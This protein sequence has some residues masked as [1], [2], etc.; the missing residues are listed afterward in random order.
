MRATA[1]ALTLAFSIA[2]DGLYAAPV[3]WTANAAD[4]DGVF[5]NPVHWSVPME[6]LGV[7][8]LVSMKDNS[9][10]LRVRVPEGLDLKTCWRMQLNVGAGRVA[11]F[12]ASNATLTKTNLP[13]SAATQYAKCQPGFLVSL[14]GKP[15]FNPYGLDSSSTNG[16]YRIENA[17]VVVSNKVDGANVA[18]VDF[19]SGSYDFYAPNGHPLG[20]GGRLSIGPVPEALEKISYNFRPGVSAVLPWLTYPKPE[21]GSIEINIEDADVYFPCFYPQDAGASAVPVHTLVSVRGPSAV[22]RIDTFEDQ[23][24]ETAPH[25]CRVQLSEGATLTGLDTFKAR[26]G[27]GSEFV[28]V[29]SNMVKTNG[30]IAIRA[31]FRLTNSTIRASGYLHLYRGSLRLMDSSISVNGFEIARNLDNAQ[32]TVEITGENHVVTNYVLLC[33][34]KDKTGQRAVLALTNCVVSTSGVGGGTACSARDPTQDGVAEVF[35]NGATLSTRNSGS[36]LVACLNGVYLGPDGLTLD[37]GHEQTIF[38]RFSD[39]PGEEGLLA[40]AGG[41]KKELANSETSVSRIVARGGTTEIRVGCV[42]ATR[43]YATETGAVLDFKGNDIGQGLVFSGDGTFRNLY[44]SS[45]LIETTTGEGCETTGWPKF[46][47]A[48][49]AGDVAVKIVSAPG[50]RARAG[51][52]IV[53]EFTDG[54]PDLSL[55]KADGKREDVK[56]DGNLV[57][58]RVHDSGL[59]VRVR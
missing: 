43:H 3:D 42:P 23:S 48:V 10:D 14:G 54:V 22:L 38:Q 6:S 45:C 2:T 59:A 11:T 49:L 34:T 37:C 44:A 27:A 50:A 56:A 28:L 52:H 51:W 1:G 19:L 36:G 55:W 15:V 41:A 5:T 12:D 40:L 57:L 9:G 29:D 25:R 58:A 33:A 39:A 21:N 17:L 13:P 46:Q 47:S 24:S 18:S 8:D 7:D 53:A 31:D 30:A 32:A 26:T 4:P 16:D 35:A 20:S